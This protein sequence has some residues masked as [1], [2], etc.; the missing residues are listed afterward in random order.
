MS[1]I[2]LTIVVATVVGSGAAAVNAF[3]AIRNFI[4][5]RRQ[6]D[7]SA[8]TE[9]ASRSG[10]VPTPTDPDEEPSSPRSG[11]TTQDSEARS[12]SPEAG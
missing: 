9:S 1:A 10:V 12:R 7:R 8:A 5:G 6:K 11:P 2:Q 4:D 3:V